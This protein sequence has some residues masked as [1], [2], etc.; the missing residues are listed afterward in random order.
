MSFDSIPSK[1]EVMGWDPPHL[2]DFLRRVSFISAPAEAIIITS[3]AIFM[4]CMTMKFIF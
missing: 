4:I 2:A 3:N 1:S